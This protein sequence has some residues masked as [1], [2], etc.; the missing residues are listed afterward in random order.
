ME[1]EAESSA[2]LPRKSTE[3][4]ESLWAS[5]SLF[6]FASVVV[7][8]LADSD[9]GHEMAW[10]IYL[11]G[12]VPLLLMGIFSLAYGRKPAQPAAQIGLWVLVLF[13]VVQGVF[14][15]NGWPL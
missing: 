7:G 12:W 14:N 4:Y 8:V 10:W 11:A 6:T 9:R 1:H 15:S 3:L 13:G 5:P 2:P